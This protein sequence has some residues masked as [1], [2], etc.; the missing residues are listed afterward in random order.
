MEN[1]EKRVRAAAAARGITVAELERRAGLSNGAVG[2]M[3]KSAPSY[4][5][6]VKLADALHMSL[7]VLC[8]RGER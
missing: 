8:G 3:G 4:D 5:K 2:K 7:D 1:L 6:V